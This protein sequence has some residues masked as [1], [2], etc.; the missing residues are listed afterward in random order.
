MS[1]EEKEI[2]TIESL[3]ALTDEVQMEEVDYRGKILNVQFCELTE[4]EEPTGSFKDDFE[5]EEERMTY[6]QELG[7][8]RVLKMIEKA[9]EKVPE[10]K[11][12]DS[13]SWSKLPTTLRYAI[14][15]TIMAINT[16]VR[17][18]FTMG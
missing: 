7:T 5:T 13:E 4:E 16:E 2:W 18:N 14:A 12:L 10:N 9:N 8:L 11:I 17:E 15:N 6:Y 3:V 1:K